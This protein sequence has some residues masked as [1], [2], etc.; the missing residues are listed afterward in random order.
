MREIQNDCELL[1]VP[2]WH[3]NGPLCLCPWPE[4]LSRNFDEMYREHEKFIENK[5]KSYNQVQRNFED[6]FGDIWVKLIGSDILNKFHQRVARM[7]RPT[8]YGHEAAALLG[9]TL[10]EFNLVMRL[11][12]GTMKYKG[13]KP[14]EPTGLTFKPIKGTLREKNVL[15]Q[16]EDI[17]ELD[18]ALDRM[19]R[20]QP[21][22]VT[23]PLGATGFK[24]YLTQAIHNHFANWCRTRKRKYQDLLLPSTSIMKVNDLGSYEQIGHNF[25]ATDWESRLV[26]MTMNDED[27]ISVVSSVER[28]FTAAGLNVRAMSDVDA[29]GR[30]T[31]EA[32]MAL[33]LLDTM[34]EGRA[35]HPEPSR[36]AGA[37]RGGSVELKPKSVRDPSLDARH[38]ATNFGDGRTIREAVKVQQRAEIRSRSRVTTG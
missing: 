14:E 10:G 34:A 38:E 2:I 11:K 37:D 1:E 16:R 4:G 29:E 36:R 3:E 31:A 13:S 15:Y 6:L 17:R 12:E 27:M 35:L 33:E 32:Q 20:S 9:L 25:E 26:A 22:R 30:P 24:A 18:E 23:F 28:E 7:L 5:I 21:R 19:P 8:L